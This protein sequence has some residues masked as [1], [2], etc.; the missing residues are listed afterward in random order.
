M[1]P[2]SVFVLLFVPINFVLAQTPG[3]SPDSALAAFK[4]NY[5]Q[6]KVFLQTD[7]AWY[8]PGETIWMKAWCALD[9][10]PSYLSRVLYV[11]LV[12]DQG[13]VISKKMYKLKMSMACLNTY[14]SK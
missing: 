4:N 2:L 6:E 8:F 9:G 10:A 3:T 7:K 14:L 12:N 13:E 1:K 11:D 5:P